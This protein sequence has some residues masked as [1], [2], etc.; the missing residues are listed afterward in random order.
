MTLEQL[1]QQMFGKSY[2]DLSISEQ[3]K[4]DD[5]AAAMKP[6]AGTAPAGPGAAPGEQSNYIT[7]RGPDGLLHRY[8]WDPGSNDYT[9][10][11]GVTQAAPQSSGGTSVVV[12]N[13]PVSSQGAYTADEARAQIQRDG[14]TVVER[15]GVVVGTFPDGSSVQFD[16]IRNRDGTTRFNP[17]F[18]PAPTAS[19]SSGL[20]GPSKVSPYTSN[21]VTIWTDEDVLASGSGDPIVGRTVNGVFTRNPRYKGTAQAPAQ[22]GATSAPTANPATAG[23]PTTTQQT[24]Q[25]AAPVNGTGRNYSFPTAAGGE[26][27]TRYDP[28]TNTSMGISGAYA[29]G[30][31]AITG[32][33]GGDKSRVVKDPRYAGQSTRYR[34][35]GAEAAGIG[36]AVGIGRRG[37]MR[38]LAS[39]GFFT[40]PDTP[41]EFEQAGIAPP[42][43]DPAL[44]LPD[45]FP[46]GKPIPGLAEGGNVLAGLRYNP[47]QPAPDFSDMY[48]G[49]YLSNLYNR[50]A[51][52]QEQMRQGVKAGES[53]EGMNRGIDN[54]GLGY[55]PESY[56]PYLQGEIRTP[57]PGEVPGARTND[58][59]LPFWGANGELTYVKQ[60][61]ERKPA[62]R[63]GTDAS[64]DFYRK[65]YNAYAEPKQSFGAGFLGQFNPSAPGSGGY[66]DVG[67]G[68]ASSFGTT[69]P[70]SLDIRQLL[71]MLFGGVPAMAGGGTVMTSEPTL[72]VGMQTGQPKFMLGEAGPEMMQV[73][74]MSQPMQ[75]PMGQMPMT[76]S[77][78]MNAPA[79]KTRQPVPLIDPARA[80]MMMRT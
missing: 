1:A 30:P 50:Y 12:Q 43:Y 13:E 44:L 10:D 54:K 8:D 66:G 18:K 49:D 20:S 78:Y 42:E 17:T 29:T 52:S 40:N 35:S 63:W 27:Q 59:W 9:I 48:G 5:A 71:A 79:Y 45:D 33:E 57:M 2:A 60:D 53:A 72:G 21:G 41:L 65:S 16:P 80:L 55:I 68:T 36:T 32:A 14:G 46:F 51:T 6:I 75:Q 28:A 74:P 67:G 25:T 58:G 7:V 37:R 26:G 11:R 56:K 38:E 3:I 4:V 39:M 69:N 24:P 64:G 73:T 62:V 23:A 61:D 22:S 31:G 15:G 77:P 34:D 70:Y 19:S 47:N 76:A